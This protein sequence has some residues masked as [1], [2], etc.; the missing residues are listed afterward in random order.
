MWFGGEGGMI[1]V[2][3]GCAK[4]TRRKRLNMEKI[5]CAHLH[6]GAD[7]RNN[8]YART[9]KQSSVGCTAALLC[10]MRVVGQHYA[11]TGNV[12]HRKDTATD[13]FWVVVVLD[14]NTPRSLPKISTFSLLDRVR[15]NGQVVDCV[16]LIRQRIQ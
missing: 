14:A 6:A 13:I 3:C 2:G 9:T 16:R 15:A 12:I 10:A 4:G 5:F 11:L 8:Q 7:M 1:D